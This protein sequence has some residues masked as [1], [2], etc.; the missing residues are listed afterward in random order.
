MCSNRWSNSARARRARVPFRR[1][2]SSGAEDLRDEP[3]V[4]DAFGTRRPPPLRRDDARA[5][6]SAMLQG[7]EPIVGQDGG[8]RMAEDGENAA[9]VL[10]I[11]RVAHERASRISSKRKTA[12]RLRDLRASIVGIPRSVSDAPACLL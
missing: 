3:H 8:V 7:E 1:S 4:R 11:I 6:L 2:S 12:F 9:L 5:F 10:R